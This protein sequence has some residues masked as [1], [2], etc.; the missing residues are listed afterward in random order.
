MDEQ[1]K[2]GREA[3]MLS[4]IKSRPVVWIF[5]LG[6]IGL[7][8]RCTSEKRLP[9][10]RSI[11]L[12]S[13]E[14]DWLSNHRVI[15]LAPDPNFPPIEFLDEEGRYTGI[16]A[17]YAALLEKRINIRFEIVGLTSWDDVLE[18]ARRKK[19][20]VLGAA[21]ETR[22]RSEYMSF[23]SP[24]LRLPVVIIVRN[25]V[26]G[27]FTLNDLEGM[28]VSVISG[29]AE[30]EYIAE[31][32]PHLDIDVV[33][34]V[35]TGLR[36]VAFG[37]VDA[38]VADL[39]SVSYH[40]EKEGISNLRLAGDTG[41]WIRLAFATRKDWPELN[42]ILEKGLAQIDADERDAIYQKWIRL[43][44]KSLIREKRYWITLIAGLG[45][46]FL[47]FVGV[48]A[49]NRSLK[50]QVSLRTDALNSELSERKRMEGALRESETKYRT[51]TENVNI[52]I[53]RM[54]PEPKGRFVE[55]NP[56][57]IKMFGYDS[58]EE[59]LSL[60][61]ANLYQNPQDHKTLGQQLLM[62]G[63]VK[64]REL[65]FTKK[66]GTHFMGSVSA[67]VVKDENGNVLCYD[68]IVEDV[69]DA[70][71]AKAELMDMNT[72]LH[73]LIQAIPD[74]VYFKDAEGRNLIVNRAFEALVGMKRENIIGKTD[75]DILPP[76]LAKRCR[77]SDA[78]AMKYKEPHRY[79]E[80]SSSKDGGTV[81]FETIKA[82]LYD[83]EG[84]ALG[85][86][87]VSRDVTERRMAESALQES[88]EWLRTV[89]NGSRDAV[90]ITGE[91]GRFVD[92]NDAGME[93]T[94]YSKEEL[95]RMAI[96][97]LHDIEDLHA[98]NAY[99]R[100]IMDGE[101]I[102]SEAKLRNRAG[103]KCDTEFNNRR[104]VIG[105]KRY[106][107]TV[108]RNIT[109]RKQSEEKIR[110]SLK[111]KEVLLKEIHHRVKNNL[112]IICSLLNLQSRHIK[113]ETAL[114]MFRESQG[115]VRS[116]AL[117]HEKLYGSK[118]LARVDFQ[119]YIQGL[120]HDLFR[121]YKTDSAKIR[122]DVDVQGVS[123]GIDSAVPCGLIINELVSNALKYAFPSSWSGKGKIA[124]SLKYV[125]D[126]E[127]E[128]LVMDNGVGLPDTVDFKNSE[129]LGMKLVYIL[130]EE[131][132]EGKVRVDRK[133]GSTFSVQFR[134]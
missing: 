133:K 22:Q 25:E 34:D 88:E 78:H 59:L 85:L 7:F 124:I 14:K 113:D 84:N 76:E 43:V 2:F 103:K 28:R 71:Q 132:L 92:V 64:N 90:F 119:E 101:E 18:N 112:Q 131:Q 6:W 5:L 32:Y 45:I 58:K 63:S 40:I 102:T 60:H 46:S 120:V 89:F 35:K 66:D 86:V 104:I 99:F 12:T 118:D 44:Q 42:A 121:A 79:E 116:M 72:R 9:D 94:G 77:K 67:V 111:E 70:K 97:D 73:T 24:Y 69:T 68:G 21:T 31:G 123:L 41:Y 105:S 65:Q 54:T 122:L 93:L 36:K 110:K 13:E 74:V 51:L 38:M 30:H 100:R 108:A 39:A 117:I 107:H 48:I 10:E 62:N 82:P 75:D 49:W 20:D 27:V 53:Y 33:P 95:K 128:L 37:M 96:P 17:D 29:Y 83:G 8:F 23:T 52:G 4:V 106:M 50:N 26:K 125:G 109:E 81:F 129:S 127:V 134:V 98:Y 130:A 55:A 91:D 61:A 80:C 3:G 114:E 126:D 16:A 1:S 11:R 115:R 56:A 19:V 57:L 87:G 15:R 47:V